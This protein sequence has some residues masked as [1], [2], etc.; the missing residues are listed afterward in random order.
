[1]L[2]NVLE[3]SDFYKGLG[4]YTNFTTRP[5]QKSPTTSQQQGF[6]VLQL[7]RAKAGFKNLPAVSEKM[8]F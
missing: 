1:M 5:Q 4:S 2:N 3:F 7:R 8:Q 6:Q